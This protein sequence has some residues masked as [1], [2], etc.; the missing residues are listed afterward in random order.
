[1]P[2]LY[3]LNL[4]ES[5]GSIGWMVP[6]VLVGIQWSGNEV[7]HWLGLRKFKVSDNDTCVCVYIYHAYICVHMFVCTL[8]E[9]EHLKHACFST[10]HGATTS[11]FHA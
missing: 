2:S 5:M 10:F 11:D 1:M 8:L 7:L 3:T 4:L 9:M 6:S